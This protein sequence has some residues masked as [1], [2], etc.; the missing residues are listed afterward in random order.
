MMTGLP[1][2]RFELR[3]VAEHEWVILDHRYEADDPRRTVGRVYQVDDY[4]VEV[5]W[6][7]EIAAATSYMTPSDAFDDV[8]RLHNPSR[9][10]RPIMTPH[11]PPLMAS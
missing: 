11:Q 7:R 8:Q 2:S 1:D 4:E 6:L 10:T 9:A 3:K 5:M